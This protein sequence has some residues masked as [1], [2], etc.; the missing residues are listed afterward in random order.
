[1]TIRQSSSQSEGG[2][3][4]KS[5]GK[6]T[7]RLLKFI[8]LITGAFVLLIGS[9]FS[10]NLSSGTK[11]AVAATASV[12]NFRINSNTPGTVVDLNG[13]QVLVNVVAGQTQVYVDCN[14]TASILLV[15]E[16]P[17]LAAMIVPPGDQTDE[18]G[19]VNSKPNGNTTGCP[20]ALTGGTC[21]DYT[22]TLPSP[23]TAGLTATGASGPDPNA[24][25][26][27][28]Q[29]QIND[30]MFGCAVV[31]A[32]FTN[33]PSKA[34]GALAETLAIYANTPNPLGPPTVAVSISGT[35]VNLSDAASSLTSWGYNS[36]QQIQSV[37]D[38]VPAVTAPSTA[39]SCFTSTGAPL[40]GYT[41]SN[42]II[43]EIQ[44]QTGGPIVNLSS[45]GDANVQISNDC[46]LFDPTNLAN[47]TLYGPKLSG[48]LTI[49]PTALNL[50]SGNYNI[51]IC[52][53]IVDSFINSNDNNGLCLGTGNYE[54]ASTNLSIS[55]TGALSSTSVPTPPTTI[56]PTTSGSVV[57]NA[58]SAQTGEPFLGESILAGTGLLVG[59]TMVLKL[60]RSKKA[61]KKGTQKI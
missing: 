7:H 37:L 8:A 13:T 54:I 45:L 6:L 15:G 1:M 26:P 31:A 44:N 60:R 58:T 50:P 5:A 14:S 61:I 47:S 3:K 42:Q 19:A 24:S 48:S 12:C 36:V 2:F 20:D 35:T 41:P 59:F 53:D 28:T 33:P 22:I 55:A 10:I 46:Y 17:L 40:F 16:A 56:P 29:Q 43:A 11:D 4:I 38:S 27:P 32:G 34:V 39:T 30:G 23:F 52:E 21:K 51:Y 57:P 25:C 18:L 49:N 9:F